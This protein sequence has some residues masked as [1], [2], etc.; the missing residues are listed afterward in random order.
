MKMTVY[1][2]TYITALAIV[3]CAGEHKTISP[4]WAVLAVFGRVGYIVH[5][6]FKRV[7]PRSLIFQ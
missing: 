5:L 3:S 7:R 4:K 1:I 6:T 2:Y